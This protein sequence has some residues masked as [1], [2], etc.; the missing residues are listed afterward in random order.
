MKFGRRKRDEVEVADAVVRIGDARQRA[1]HAGAAG[2]QL[3]AELQ[4]RRH[5]AETVG[6]EPL[7]LDDLVEDVTVRTR[8]A[9]AQIDAEG[10]RQREERGDGDEGG[11]EVHN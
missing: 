2:A 8:L 6:A 9:P 1:V 11:D 3:G 4:Q 10:H 7:G 5:L